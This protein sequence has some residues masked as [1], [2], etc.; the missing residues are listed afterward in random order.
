MRSRMHSQTL[1]PVVVPLGGRECLYTAELDILQM[2]KNGG[3][4]KDDPMDMTELPDDQS[5]PVRRG[6]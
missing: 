6:R 3:S 2:K 4:R 5:S 1:S